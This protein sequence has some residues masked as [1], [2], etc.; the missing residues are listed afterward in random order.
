MKLKLNEVEVE[1]IGVEVIE[2]DMMLE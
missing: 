1:V 2:V